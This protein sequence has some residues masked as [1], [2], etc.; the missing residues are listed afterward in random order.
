MQ[1]D[2]SNHPLVLN[3]ST[4]RKLEV[5]TTTSQLFVHLGVSIES[6]IHTTLLLLIKNNLQDLASVLLGAQSLANDLDGIDEVRED[7]VVDGSESSGTGTLLGEGGARTVGALG[8][9]EDAA[10][11]EDQ[12]VAVREL[13]LE[14]AGESV[15]I[16]ILSLLYLDCRERGGQAYL[17]CTRWK[18]CR[19]GTGTKMTIAF[20]PWPTSIYTRSKISMRAPS[21]SLP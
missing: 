8:P 4:L 17:C 11:G 19:E 10:R 21:E 13:L 1:H 6:V 5:N 9:G 12:D 3:S 7:G 2:F 18:P 14:F 20:L 16:S 15:I